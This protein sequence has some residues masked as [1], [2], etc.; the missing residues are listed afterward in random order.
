MCDCTHIRMLALI[1]QKLISKLNMEK[2]QPKK[3]KVN[4][5]LG[6]VAGFII[7]GIIKEIIW[8]LI[9]N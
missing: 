3:S 9:S 6:I 7:Y 4:F 5:F 8:P 1:A 2:E